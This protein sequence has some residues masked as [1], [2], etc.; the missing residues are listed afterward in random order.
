MT[1][2][3]PKRWYDYALRRLRKSLLVSLLTVILCLMLFFAVSSIYV[4]LFGR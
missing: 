2:D 3:E 4:R 1:A